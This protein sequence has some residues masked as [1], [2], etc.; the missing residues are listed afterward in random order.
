MERFFEDVLPDLYIEPR[1]D[2][3]SVNVSFTVPGGV[4]V[5]RVSIL[6]GGEKIHSVAGRGRPRTVSVEFPM[7]GFRPWSTDSPFLYTLAIELSRKGKPEITRQNFGMRKFHVQDKRIFMNNRPLYI[8]GFI[9]GREAHDHPNLQGLSP[10]EYYEKNIRAAKAFGFNFVRFHSKVPPREFFDA[11]DRLGFLAHIEVRKYYGKYQKERELMDHDPTLVDPG[12]WRKAILDLRNHTSL[13]A[14]CLGNE[15]NTPG[16][17][18]EV[19]ARRRQLKRLDSTRLFIDTCAR[20]EYDRTGIDFDV[21]HMGYFMPFGRHHD[22]FNSTENW[23]I[24]GSV[25]DK[26]MSA[27]GRDAVVRREIPVNF[28][29]MA[30]EVGHYMQ[31]RDLDSL[32]RKFRTSGVEEPWWV[33]ELIKLRELKGQKE[34]YRGL[35]QASRRF[36]FIWHKQMFEAVRRSPILNGFHFLQFSDTERY[37]NSNGLVDVF[38]DYK[39]GTRPEEYLPFNAD[40]VIVADL[41]RRTFFEG[42]TLEVPV[43]FSNNSGKPVKEAALAWSLECVGGRYKRLCGELS[44]LDMREGLQKV[45]FL[46][47]R[48]PETAR[49][50]ALRLTAAIRPTEG[51]ATTNSWNVWVFPDRPGDMA[52]KEATIVLRDVDIC[53]RY[54]SIR[55]GGSLSRPRRLLVTDRFTEPVF[56]HLEKGG[57]VLMLYRVPE[58]RNLRAWHMKEKAAPAEKY[59]M[60]STWDRFKQVI[61]DRGH[62]LGG[63]MRKHRALARFPH[64]GY[65]DF[66]FN[67]LIEDC[68]KF[69]LDGFPV[70]VAPAVQGVDKASRDRYDV[71]T[72]GLRE[73]QPEWT[74]RRFAYLFDLRVGRGRLMMSGFNFTGLNGNVP[75]VCGMFE[76]LAACVAS[77]EWRPAAKIPVKVLKGYLEEKGRSPR[78]RER[79]MTQYWQLD[80]APLESADYWRM[81]EKWIREGF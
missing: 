15:I 43:W 62:N 60:P 14:Y 63:F 39:E 20:G 21:Q 4:K 32:R 47:V 45:A 42:D 57:D 35:V 75:E 34:E 12:V 59:Y 55:Q 10:V 77:A 6:E 7:K 51:P 64:D 29:V 13:M 27:G 37:E 69:S 72:F 1:Y 11:A 30:H 66:Q 49:A 76:S 46:R 40:N 73:L 54:G 16:R 38:D 9:R 65:V 23:A 24:F 56:R 61:W 3:A 71:F 70:R 53:R 67:G 79:M 8:R 28:P 31:L 26:P 25:E 80:D 68:D 17:R 48:L 33:G 41:P 5:R 78:V 44:R 22:M 19:K 18:P 50:R 81:S 36:Q 52:V 58:N 2:L 74:M